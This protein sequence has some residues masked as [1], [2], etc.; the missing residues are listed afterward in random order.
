MK[1]TIAIQVD[2]RIKPEI[3]FHEDLA[4]EDADKLTAYATRLLRETRETDY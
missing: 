1:V 3:I 2:E 4:D